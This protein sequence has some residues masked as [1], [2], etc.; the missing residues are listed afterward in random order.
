MV[1]FEWFGQTGTKA[2][3][4]RLLADPAGFGPVRFG[5]EMPLGPAFFDEV[6]ERIR[7]REIVIEVGAEVEA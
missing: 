6:E 2:I 3:P 4:A 5:C 7:T 1:E